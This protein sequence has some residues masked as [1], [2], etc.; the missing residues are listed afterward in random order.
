MPATESDNYIEIP[1]EA[2]RIKAIFTERPSDQQISDIKQWIKDG[3]PTFLNPYHT[4]T[5]PH[6]DSRLIYC[7]EFDLP[8][9]D[10]RAGR[11]APCPCC[12]PNHGKYGR[13]G[14]IAW[15]PDEGVI[16]LLGPDCYKAID[17][18][19]HEFAVAAFRKEERRKREV[20]Y[21]LSNEEKLRLA[22]QAL[23][24]GRE[25]A[26][27]LD[28]FG[29]TFRK[30]TYD[31]MNLDLWP[32]IRRGQLHL[33]QKRTEFVGWGGETKEVDEIVEYAKIRGYRLL[34]PEAKPLVGLFNQ[35]LSAFRV[36][37][38]VDDWNSYVVNKTDE[39]RNQLAMLFNNSRNHGRNAL[40][41]IADEKKLASHETLATLRAW[42]R[43]PNCPYPFHLD[44][45][46]NKVVV[47]RSEFVAVTIK[48]PDILDAYEA[49]PMI[50]LPGIKEA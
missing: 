22:L 20:R 50:H 39:E 49:V 17:Q 13:K 34:D 38:S 11:L 14:K 5:K 40:D 31:T 26:E 8:E 43:H 7:G 44:F 32:H 27:A 42:G 48:I 41:R 37:D 28:E 12:T 18:E 33:N 2:R 24:R 19:G 46:A 15:F 9:K 1:E 21:L 4:H 10:I 47:G 16:R 36:L 30:K 23:T 45:D 3:K 25:L 6:P 29:R 35:P